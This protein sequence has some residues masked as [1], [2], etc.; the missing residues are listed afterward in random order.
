MRTGQESEA[1]RI[2]QE[3][4]Y[5]E[6]YRGRAETRAN[7]IH[8]KL[9]KLLSKF[10]YNS[11]QK[12]KNETKILDIGCG[13]GELLSDFTGK[14]AC[15]GVDLSSSAVKK[16][17]LRGI[18]AYRHDI[19]KGLPFPAQYFHIIVMSEVLEHV[20]Q[21]DRVLKEVWRILNEKGWFILTIPN[22]NSP[23]S[24]IMQVLFDYPPLNSAR[25]KSAHV[26]DFTLRTIKKAL[27]NNG[28][29]I[30]RIEGTLVFPLDNKFSKFMANIIPRL[31]ET[32]ILLNAKERKPSVTPEVTFDVR[33]M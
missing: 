27:T 19:E 1:V 30:C 31:S 9:K 12:N 28:F 24:W 18:Q 20:I 6:A 16:A 7:I 11:V 32:I 29:R 14:Y 15:F 10:A 13:T 26:R 23:I 21:T 8:E 33:E 3:R 5:D 2:F 25:Y 17:R 4:V 22:I